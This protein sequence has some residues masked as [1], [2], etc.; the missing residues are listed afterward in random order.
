MAVMLAMT[1]ALPMM[2]MVV[3]VVMT[4]VMGMSVLMPLLMGMS[5]LMPLPVGR[6]A[7]VFMV[8]DAMA[9]RGGARVL[10]ED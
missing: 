8:M 4:L 10:A 5:V 2:V 3:R 9:R 7:P 1:V 6:R